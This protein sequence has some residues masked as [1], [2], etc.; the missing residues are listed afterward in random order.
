MVS[1]RMSSGISKVGEE[2]DHNSRTASP[3]DHHCIVL[4]SV[5]VAGSPGPRQPRP[6]DRQPE[7]D[8]PDERFVV[9]Q[10]LQVEQHGT[11]DER[12]IASVRF[13][14][15]R[16]IVGLEGVDTMDD[17]EALAGAE[18]KMPASAIAPLPDGIFY[19][20]DLVGCEVRDTRGG[21]RQRDRVDGP[22]E[23]SRL[24][25]AGT[26]G[27]VLVPLVDGICA[28]VDPAAQGRSSSIRRTD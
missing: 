21:D 14:Q 11:V 20:H 1:W 15:G 22:M 24:V 9:G 10:R 7:T 18:L 5:L 12:R 3:S 26:G 19:Q 17:A 2:P 25:M 16:P 8:F 27:E 13:H 23:R 4:A 28:E 6:G